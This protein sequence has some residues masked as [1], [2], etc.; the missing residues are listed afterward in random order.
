MFFYTRFF[1]ETTMRP[2]RNSVPALSPIPDSLR[3]RPAALALAVALLPTI[4]HAADGIFDLGTL[5]GLS[6][7]AWDVSADGNLMVGQANTANNAAAHA[8]LWTQAGGMFDLGTL[9]GTYSVAYA[10]SA[11]GNVVVG[12]ASNANQQDRA[13]RWTQAGGMADL[14]TLGGTRSSAKA[15]SADGNV[16]VGQANTANNA[17]AHAFLWTQAGGMADLGT[18]G[19]RNSA[20]FAV[21]ADGNVVVGDASDANRQIRAFR[22]TQAGGMADLGTLGG[23]DSYARA[24]S[25]DG[26][27]VVGAASD[28]NTRNR[29]FRW[30]QAGGMVDLGT[31]GGTYAY[32]WADSVAWDVS[33]DGN[34]VVGDALNADKVYRAFRWTQADGM[35]DLGTLGGVNSHAHAVS[36]DGNVVVG[37]ASIGPTSR[38]FR[39]SQASGMQSVEQWLA[40]NGV[41]VAPGLETDS[42]TGTSANGS[43]VVGELKNARAFLARVTSPVT[44]PPG[45]GIGSG[46]I[47]VLDY[48]S[49]LQ[50]AGYATVQVIG[51]ADLVLNGLNGSPLRGLPAA[52]RFNTWLA[53]DWGRQKNTAGDGDIGAGE[54]GLAYGVS[55]PVRIK[56]AVGRTY[57][58]QG[59]AYDGKSTFRGTYVVPEIVAAIPGSS[60]Y[61]STSGYYNSGDADI[62]RGYLNAGTPVKSDGSPD[63]SSGAVRLRLDWL[64]AVQAGHL[65]L[66]PYGSLSR[67][68]GRTD[69][70]TETGGGFPVRWDA[71]TEYSSIGRVGAEAA[72]ALDERWALLGKLEYVHR[73][74]SQSAGA[75]GTVLGLGTFA[76]NGL[77]YKENW[78]RANVGVEGKV[79]PGVAAVIL[80]AS[81]ETNGPTHW[82]YASYR[83]DF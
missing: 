6:S 4:G 19:G 64:N 73:F 28:A 13:F 53:G 56:V 74:D 10:V 7:D 62:K 11:D 63:T 51:Q 16:V 76:T 20:A 18:V 34:V 61:V 33:A 67:Y 30:T 82:A 46:L 1:R 79:G 23:P 80:N 22:W 31:L 9:G 14:G 65:R 3:L 32:A 75:S 71:R 72:Y 60:L 54:V 45:S 52:G 47:D 36:A 12:D 81:T 40:A 2:T 77:D 78:G 21:S 41:T 68:R 48:S 35:I 5:G 55:E 66:T 38:A 8:F 25:A 83:Y 37:W 24:V 58:D 39:W 26:N 70:Y 15:V 27:V 50:G 44:P 57:N 29:A 49:T 42:A 59:M 43:V 17:A 69:G